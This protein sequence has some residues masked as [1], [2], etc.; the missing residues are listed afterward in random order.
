MQR[1][2]I[3]APQT[4]TWAADMA[5]EELAI[6]DAL[7]ARDET[8]ACEARRRHIRNAMSSVLRQIQ[9]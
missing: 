5:D 7:A 2:L 4:I 3:M 6:V 8:V 9:Q 1:V